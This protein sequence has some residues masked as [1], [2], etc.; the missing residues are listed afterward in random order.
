MWMGD[1]SGVLRGGLSPLEEKEV[2]VKGL[3]S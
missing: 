1:R 2:E 3:R